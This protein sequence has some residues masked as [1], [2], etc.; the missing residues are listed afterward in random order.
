MSRRTAGAGPEYV[1][2]RPMPRL[3][4]TWAGALLLVIA[5]L[6]G[7]RLLANPDPLTVLDRTPDQPAMT[8]IS[9]H[10]PADSVFLINTFEW[11]SGD[12]RPSDAGGWLP[13]LANRS[14]AMPAS[15]TVGKEL[16]HG[17]GGIR[18]VCDSA[19]KAG[20][21]HLYLGG[22]GG[23]IAPSLVSSSGTCFEEVYAV[24]NVRIY[25]LI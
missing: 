22:R 2:H 14:V 8:W 6:A 4:S 3:D 1:A 7:Y 12:F 11:Q 10:V 21:T 20:V 5:W 23:I 13:Y 15:Q 18:S 9:E 17:D 16:R 19:R 24:G 25:R